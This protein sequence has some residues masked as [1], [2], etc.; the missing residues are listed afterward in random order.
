MSELSPTVWTVG[1]L[2]EAVKS[3]L[4]RSFP[5]ILVKGEVTALA[6]PGSG[7]VYF[8]LKDD[9][10]AVRCVL[11][12]HLRRYL[13]TLPEPD[14]EYLIRGKVSAYG[15]RSEYQIVVDYL[16]PVGLGALHA[17]FLELREKLAAKGYFDL[18]RKRPLPRL[19]AVLGIVT[20]LSGAAL[21]D[22]LR[23]VHA[24]RPGQRVAIAPTLVQGERA[25]SAIAAAIRLLAEHAS[26][27]VIIVGRG[28]GSPEDLWCWNEEVVVRAVVECPVP[29]ISGVGHEVD[30]SLCDLAADVRAATPTHAAEI[31]V[32]D[33]AE[34]SLKIA[35]LRRRGQ[36]S[37]AGQTAL[38][39]RRCEHA[40]HRLLREATPTALL[41][42]RLDE[43]VDRLASVMR[44]RR[45]LRQ[46][47]LTL[48]ENRLQALSPRRQ[49]PLRRE[50]LQATQIRL[51]RAMATYLVRRRETTRHRR[52]HL[53]ALT[54]QLRRAA[55][56]ELATGNHTL[57]GLRSRL[58]DVS[59]LAVLERGYAIVTNREGRI[60]TQA[61]QTAPDDTLCVR[62]HCGR[63]G[64]TV[65]TVE[66]DD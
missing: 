24:R 66:P 43:L 34:L 61:A 11:Y 32:P 35:L 9:R 27:E 62:F 20:S 26:P 41:G 3:G 57:A 56:S 63:L 4:E 25:A 58:L 42:R 59:P 39:R 12:R 45:F 23:M 64:V 31:A 60:L 13:R 44:E 30:V 28:G 38:L 33:V 1:Q 53:A 21:H 54:H 37:M 36:R 55:M 47:R 18:G 22:M 5:D 8:T 49:I 50:R 6:T 10:A 16:E 7:H 15:P 52:E 14:K 19:P 51:G 46:H 17:A 2:A 29:V 65:K 48:A 40:A